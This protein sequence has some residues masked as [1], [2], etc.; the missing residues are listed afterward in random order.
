M[1]KLSKYAQHLAKLELM[2]VP[3]EV[4]IDF[5]LIIIIIH[6]RFFEVLG[7]IVKEY[8]TYRYELIS[9]IL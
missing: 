3:I 5:A 8:K 4:I 7:I 2:K 1:T 6:F 9:I